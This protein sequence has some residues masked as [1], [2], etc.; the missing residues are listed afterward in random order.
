M[1][2]SAK[3]WLILPLAA[4]LL[5]VLYLRRRPQP[6]QRAT[7]DAGDITL[8]LR[9]VGTLEPRATVAV[10][11]P[12]GGRLL[13]VGPDVGVRV[14]RGEVV[15]VAERD[16]EDRR[17]RVATASLRVAEAAGSRTDAE[18]RGAEEALADARRE[19]DRVARLAGAGAAAPAALDIERDRVSRAASALAVLLAQARRDGAQVG[20]ARLSA[21][22]E[23]ERGADQELRAPT[24]G[25]V[26]RR[27]HEA[28]DVAPPG[29]AVLVLADTTDLVVRVPFDES[30]L[31]WLTIGIDAEIR[32]FDGAGGP[33]HA[34][35][36][37]ILPEAQ[38]DTH[39]I[40]VEFRLSTPARELSVVG[41]RA[42]VIVRPRAHVPFRLPRDACMVQ[43]DATMARCTVSEGGRLAFRDVAIGRVGNEYLELR[44]EAGTTWPDF[45][46]G[47]EFPA[48]T[49]VRAN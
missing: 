31:A 1:I 24:D 33:I 3:K 35:L 41:V 28:G 45:L 29:G 6:V 36:L 22:V 46:R 30:A 7:V 16:E 39:E 11:F 4:S 21:S 48:G 19:Q 12:R 44:G 42:A 14:R 17:A 15:A 38:P 13:N 10:G 34:S 26:L 37:R 18:I 47:A 32:P 27:V 43:P 9:A 25:V 23:A 20:F 40:M 5:G 8:E 2:A 49:R